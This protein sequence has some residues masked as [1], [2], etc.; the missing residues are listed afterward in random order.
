MGTERIS[1]SAADLGGPLKA[2]FSVSDLGSAIARPTLPRIELQKPPKAPGKTQSTPIWSVP[3]KAITSGVP[4]ERNV[5]VPFGDGQAKFPGTL[6]KVT[7]VE[8]LIPLGSSGGISVNGLAGTYGGRSSVLGGSVQVNMFSDALSLGAEYRISSP[9]DG[10]QTGS[11]DLTLSAEAKLGSVELST[12]VAVASPKA[13]AN[14]RTTYS[15][16][17][18]VPLGSDT[19]LT[20]S[21]EY[22]QAATASKDR[23]TVTG[24]AAWPNKGIEVRLDTGSSETNVQ[25]R[26][27][28][29][30]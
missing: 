7:G 20:L 17:A 10:T 28:L 27:R 8:A 26:L 16:G 2:V 30:L 14:R 11:R 9:N 21:G 3:G 29:N 6:T 5:V 15:L 1:N 19:K 23:Y 4:G 24:G 25:V 18:Q 12:G 13:D 22:T